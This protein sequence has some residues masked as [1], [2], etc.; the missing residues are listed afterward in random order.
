MTQHL[1]NNETN[2]LICFDTVNKTP[3][4]STVSTANDNPTNDVTIDL[5]AVPRRLSA[6][7]MSVGSLEIPLTQWTVES[8]WNRVYFSEDFEA[9]ALPLT[10]LTFVYSLA[11]GT[12]QSSVVS[13][14]LTLNPIVAANASTDSNGHLSVTFKTQWPHQLHL[15]SECDM[16]AILLSTALTTLASP[17]S[18]RAPR[19]TQLSKNNPHL[20]IQKEHSAMTDSDANTFSLTGV[21]INSNMASTIVERVTTASPV[22]I[23]DGRS[24]PVY[25]YVY[26]S[27]IPGPQHLVRLINAAIQH[28]PIL[29]YNGV[30]F[31]F[32]PKTNKIGFHF[33]N[34]ASLGSTLTLDPFRQFPTFSPTAT[35]PTLSSSSLSSTKSRIQE[36]DITITAIALTNPSA[37]LDSL[38]SRLGFLDPATTLTSKYQ[39]RSSLVYLHHSAIA[40]DPGNYNGASLAANLNLQFN[41]FH[42]PKPFVPAAVQQQQSLNNYMAKFVFT[43]S[44]GI[45]QMFD[46]PFGQY[47]ASSF[48]T[49]LQSQMT[50][51]DTAGTTYMVSF[52]GDRFVFESQPNIARDNTCPVFGLEFSNAA[53]QSAQLISPVT[54]APMPSVS[55]RLGFSAIPYRGKSAYVSTVPVVV[56]GRYFRDT[57]VDPLQFVWNIMY[58]G[59]TNKFTIDPVVTTPVSG[60]ITTTTNDSKVTSV[61][62]STQDAHGFRPHQAITVMMNSVSVPVAIDTVI[63]AFTFT[64]DPGTH[65]HVPINSTVTNWSALNA[66]LATF[67]PL[68]NLYGPTGNLFFA[69]LGDKTVHDFQ[70]IHPSLLGFSNMSYTFPLS[71]SDSITA[72]LAAS[73]IPTGSLF[74]L[75]SSTL[76]D[77]NGPNYLLLQVVDPVISTHLQHRYQNDLK[78]NLLAKIL[79][80]VPGC[81]KVERFLHVQ[82]LLGG[83]YSIIGS[84]RLQLLNPDHTLYQLHGQDWSGTLSITAL[85]DRVQLRK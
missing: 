54:G 80:H 44:G 42:F 10:Q 3:N 67:Q 24:S 83:A 38:A 43:D 70:Q 27:P 63:D 6:I 33:Q 35:F 5:Q 56:P 84:V 11:N 62:V 15:S 25:G 45:V 8:Q 65:Y 14:P 77:L 52:K 34:I 75:T 73:A 36:P 29:A 21:P 17:L 41:R 40:I 46:I 85:Q 9:N 76:A 61:V 16:P 59:T 79:L 53:A 74:P 60:R 32:N 4:E 23:G 51:L 37:T 50:L 13:I 64:I 47:S 1:T 48:A 18:A 26:H 72:T 71:N 81:H 2:Y 31:D 66:H 78:Q 20:V 69:P 39:S 28:D 49:L 68:V 7:A 58:N 22:S 55:S 19:L 12:Q 30:R 82:G 57:S